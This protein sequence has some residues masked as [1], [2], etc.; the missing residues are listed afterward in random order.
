MRGTCSPPARALAECYVSVSSRGDV[1]PAA[2]QLGSLEKFKMTVAALTIA[3]KDAYIQRRRGEVYVTQRILT[4]GGNGG[5]ARRDEM[6]LQQGEGTDCRAGQDVESVLD[7]DAAGL[8]AA[9][10]ARAIAAGR[11]SSGVACEMKV[12]GNL[13][14]DLGEYL[15]DALAGLG[16]GLEEEQAGLLGVRLGLVLGHGT[17]RVASVRGGSGG[18]V[19]VVVV[20]GVGTCAAGRLVEQVDLVA[21]ERDD[22][23]GIRLALELLDPRL[24][25]FE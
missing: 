6:D 16:R 17:E 4:V 25:L 9:R 7:V 23:V 11:G 13:L 19:V 22:N 8:V 15:D 24:C 21:D 3:S 14:C 12:D 2:F 20:V 1:Q 5:R 18:L 10:L